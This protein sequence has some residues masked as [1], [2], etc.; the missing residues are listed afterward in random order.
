MK[1]QPAHFINENNLP[2]AEG[3]AIKYIWKN[4]KWKGKR[5]DIEKAIHY[6]EMII[7]DQDYEKK[8]NNEVKRWKKKT[9]MNVDILMEDTFYARTPDLNK[10]F[11]P[12]SKATFTILE[13]RDKRSTLEEIPIENQTNEETPK[14]NP[15]MDKPKPTEV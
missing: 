6:L 4:T 8:M 7:E 12:S 2:F 1:V 10:E 15:T 9:Y 11:P 13:N 14:E 5:K 3:N